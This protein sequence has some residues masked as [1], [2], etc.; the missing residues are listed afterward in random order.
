MFKFRVLFFYYY[1]KYNAFPVIRILAFTKHF[2]RK[3]FVLKIHDLS[4]C[5]KDN[6]FHSIRTS[7]WLV[8]RKTATLDFDVIKNAVAS[9]LMNH[10]LWQY[11]F[12]VFE[13]HYFC[14][15]KTKTL[16]CDRITL[17]FTLKWIQVSSGWFTVHRSIVMIKNNLSTVSRHEKKMAR[18]DKLLCICVF[19]S[20]FRH[21]FYEFFFPF[22]EHTHWIHRTKRKQMNRM[23]LFPLKRYFVHIVSTE[24]YGL[25]KP[26]KIFMNHG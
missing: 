16:L 26:F 11:C 21:T 7:M 3:F 4:N 25:Q 17:I 5:I 13:L 1:F 22:V 19:E 23:S 18:R 8:N 15:C 24:K 10:F 2:E 20:E 14:I 9:N 6:F 12:F